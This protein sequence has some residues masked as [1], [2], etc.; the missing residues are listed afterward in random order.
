MLRIIISILLPLILISCVKNSN[1]TFWNKFNSD[2]I[3]NKTVIVDLSSGRREISWINLNDKLKKNSFFQ[4]AN[5]NNWILND[6]IEINNRQIPKAN[7]N[8]LDK[9]TIE[10]I[11]NKV[12]PNLATNRA[13]LYIF[14]IID[15]KAK[16]KNE[17]DKKKGFLIVENNQYFKILQIWEN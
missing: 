11:G 12:I 7:L 5:E 17:T 3:D 10:V 4:Y 16:S 6:S 8:K 1:I 2:L 13:K 15:I 9:L 14:T